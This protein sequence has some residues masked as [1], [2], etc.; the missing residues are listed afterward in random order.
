MKAKWLSRLILGSTLLLWAGSG[1]ASTF[2]HQTLAQLASESH[3]VIHGKVTG[4]AGLADGDGV[5]W[6]IYTLEVQRVLSGEVDSS[7]FS[8][9]CAGGSAGGRTTE[10]VGAPSYAIGDEIVLFYTPES[11]FCQVA[12]QPQAALRVVATQSGKRALVNDAG[13][14]VVALTAD[15]LVLGSI[16]TVLPQAELQFVARTQ[17]GVTAFQE[18]TVDAPPAEATALLDELELF[19]QLYADKARKVNSTTT[20]DGAPKLSGTAVAPL[21]G[22][23]KQ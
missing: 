5:P 8:F 18:F 11:S 4:R 6:T 23:T 2:I 7:V 21:N 14:G 9:R 20:L 22:G 16:V 17:G 10:F 1:S 12:S 19:C 15:D 3:A 13:R